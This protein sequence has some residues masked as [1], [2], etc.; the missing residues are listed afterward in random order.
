MEKIKAELE[1]IKENQLKYMTLSYDL[2][3]DSNDFSANSKILVHA[4]VHNSQFALAATDN[5]DKDMEPLLLS[6]RDDPIITIPSSPEIP[7]SKKNFKK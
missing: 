6:S 2:H 1:L 4:Q 7:V 3:D 5:L